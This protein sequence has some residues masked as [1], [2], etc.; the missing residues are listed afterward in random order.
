MINVAMSKKNYLNYLLLKDAMAHGKSSYL[1]T[2]VTAYRNPTATYHAMYSS[3]FVNSLIP[4][5]A[6]NSTIYQY[7][8]SD[9]W[10]EAKTES[11]GPV[12]LLQGNYK[13]ADGATLTVHA[14]GN[15][16]FSDKDAKVTYKSNR[17]RDFNQFV[18]VSDILEMF[19]KHAAGMGLDRKQ[20]LALPIQTFLMWLVIEAA[21][22]DGEPVPEDEVKQLELALEPA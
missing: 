21:K 10:D 4:I 17:N 15:Y 2:S 11:D 9:D 13:L 19:M 7:T 6:T 18:N 16:E 22:Q 12:E 5:T 14:D 8:V 1:G 20:F 3:P